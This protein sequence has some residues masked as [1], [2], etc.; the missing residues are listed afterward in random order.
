MNKL[1]MSIDMADNGQYTTALSSTDHELLRVNINE[2]D[3]FKYI[4]NDGVYELLSNG[5]VTRVMIIR[6]HDGKMKFF[7]QCGYPQN[8]MVPCHHCI[9]LLALIDRE[10]MNKETVYKLVDDVLKADSYRKLLNESRITLPNMCYVRTKQSMIDTLDN[11]LTGNEPFV[12]T[13]LD[14]QTYVDNRGTESTHPSM[15]KRN[16]SKW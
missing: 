5:T 15:S 2:K 10:Y 16:L 7:C 4:E 8:H 6:S 13:L 11:Q 3:S 12:F 14:E 1:L 9:K